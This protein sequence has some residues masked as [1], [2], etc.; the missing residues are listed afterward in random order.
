MTI[1]IGME[2]AQYLTR[3]TGSY[4]IVGSFVYGFA[5]LYKSKTKIRP[6]CNNG[7]KTLTLSLVCKAVNHIL[8]VVQQN[9]WNPDIQGLYVNLLDSIVL[10][11]VPRKLRV[12]PILFNKDRVIRLVG[13]P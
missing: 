12:I 13:D 9:I 6:K 3:R 7:E 8:L 5:V 2:H 1:K 4:S 10:V 11:R